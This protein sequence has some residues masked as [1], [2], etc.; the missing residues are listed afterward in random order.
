MQCVTAEKVMVIIY[1]TSKKSENLAKKKCEPCKK[2]RLRKLTSN[3]KYA[4]VMKAIFVNLK[5]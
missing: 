2:R 1:Q 5:Y 4:R 3:T